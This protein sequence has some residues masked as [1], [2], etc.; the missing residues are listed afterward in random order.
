MT[1]RE[2]ADEIVARWVD[3]GFGTATVKESGKFVEIELFDDE[4]EEFTIGNYAD[5]G[6]SISELTE[7][8][9]ATLVKINGIWMQAFPK[10]IVGW[11]IG[12]SG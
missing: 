4:G 2:L 9:G 8:N 11:A 12:Y 10:H 3:G 6:I 7:F 5:P 1:L